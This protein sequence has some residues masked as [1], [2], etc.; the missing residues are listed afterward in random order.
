[1]PPGVCRIVVAACPPPWTALPTGY[2][3]GH[4]ASGTFFHTDGARAARKDV[5]TSVV[6]DASARRITVIGE[7]GRVTPRLSAAMAASFHLVTAPLKIE[8]RVSARNLNGCG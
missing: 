4:W 3:A 5:N 2:M 7:S 8:A 6:V 1:M